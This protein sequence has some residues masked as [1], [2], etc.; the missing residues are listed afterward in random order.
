M[1]GAGRARQASCVHEKHGIL[2]CNPGRAGLT[3]PC[4]RTFATASCL[5]S[6]D[7]DCAPASCHA[8]LEGGLPEHRSE[9]CSRKTSHRAIFSWQTQ[10]A[11]AAHG[12]LPCNPTRAG[13]PNT[14]ASIRR[15]GATRAPSSLRQSPSRRAS[16]VC[17]GSP[18]G[19]P[20]GKRKAD[21]RPRFNP[22]WRGRPRSRP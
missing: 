16:E 11:G 17:S 7:A 6:L 22:P 14:E 5:H 1:A 18:T 8:I 19:Y 10:F 9:L 21:P 2:P 4:R 20:T 13:S 3:T 15:L 12:I